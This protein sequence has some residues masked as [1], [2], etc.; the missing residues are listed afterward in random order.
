MFL[1]PEHSQIVTG[2]TD[3]FTVDQPA[4]E[5]AAGVQGGVD[6]FVHADADVKSG[7]T[8]KVQSKKSLP[9]VLSQ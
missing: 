5:A 2:L 9:Y 6:A 3:I 8:S 7:R 4:G 1:V